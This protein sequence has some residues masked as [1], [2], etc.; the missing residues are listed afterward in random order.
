MIITLLSNFKEDERLSMDNYRDLLC[1]NFRNNKKFKIK[2][3]I[4]TKSN[5]FSSMRYSRYIEYPKII[6]KIDSNLFHV[7]EDGYA[8]L[9][10]SLDPKKSIISVFDLMP[11]IFWKK[12]FYMTKPPLFYLYS[13][14]YLK[15]YK[16]IIA[17]SENT[18]KDLINLCSIKE[19]RIK[20]ATKVLD[21]VGLLNRITHKP[22][23]LSGGQR[24][25]VAIARALVN[26]PSIILADEPTANLDS[27]TGSALLDMMKELNEKKNITFV[28][29]THDQMIMD[30]AKRLV[31]LKD[32]RIN[33][34]E[35]R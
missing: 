14:S 23:E 12:K 3:F 24:Q 5:L 9:I 27:H 4:P 31:I 26:N 16:T 13:L 29:S 10:R 11:L 18:K 30:R 35:V 19:E 28:F 25:R 21:D 15:F 22:N 7:V 20:K 1:N 17:C 33:R 2:K 6:K 8:H 34:D 32:G